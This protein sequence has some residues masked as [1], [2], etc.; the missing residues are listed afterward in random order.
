MKTLILS[1]K[2]SLFWILFIVAFNSF[3]QTV[4]YTDNFESGF[5]NWVD[6]G[7]NCRLTNPTSL[8]SGQTVELRNGTGT[9]VTYTNNINFT[10]YTSVSIEFIFRV[11]G[12][13]NGEDFDLQYSNNGGSS[14]TNLFTYTVG[15]NILTNT[16]YSHSI[17]LT[18]AAY[19]FSN[20]S[21]FRF[22]SNGNHNQDKVFIDNVVI[23]VFAGPEIDVRGSNISIAN[24]DT[25]PSIGDNTDYGNVN[26]GSIV[27]KVFTIHNTGSGSLNIS[28]ITLSN[29]TDFAITGTPYS[30]PVAGGNSTSFNLRFKTLTVGTKTTTVTITNNDTDEGTYSFLVRAGAEQNFF[31][32]DGDGVYDNVDIDDDNDG[33]VDSEEELACKSSPTA[34]SVNYKFLNETFGTG[35]GRTTINTNNYAATTSYCYEDGTT[36]TNTAACPFMSSRILDDGEYTV[37]SKIT[38]TV[39]SDPENIHGDLAWTNAPDHTPGDT[40]GRMAVFNASF[41]PGVFY[42]TNITGVLSNIPITY[43]FWAMN[44]MSQAYYPGTIH[45]N[46]TVQFLDFS[47]NI[48]ATI[49][50]G[51]FGRCSGGTS[52]NSCSQNVWKQ[53]TTSVNLGD[54]TDFKV[55]FINN[56]S[57]GGGNDLAIDDIVIAQTLCDT[58]G[59]GVADVFDLDSDNDGIPDVVEAGLGNYSEGKA[60]LTNTIGWVDTNGNGMLDLAEGHITLDSDGDGR[61]NYLDLDSDNDAIFDVDE[62]G[63]GNTADV[64]FQNGD[65]DIDGDGVGDGPDSDSVRL[66]DFDSDGTT[67][68]FT[69]GI[70]DIYD[71]YNGSSFAAAYGNSNQ[72]S[73]YTYFVK[74][75]DNDGIPDYIDIT[76]DGSTYDISHTLYASLDTNNDGRV[77]G[78]GD[79]DKDGILDLFDTND[80]LFGSPRDLDR[81]LHLYF[82]GRNDYAQDV[83][84]IN[85]WGEVSMMGWIKI[86]PTGTGVQRVMGQNQFYL[87]LQSNRTMRVVANGNLLTS[88]RL[89]TNRWTHVAATYSSSS[90]LLKLYINGAEVGSTSVSGSLPSDSAL[91]TLGKNATA[92]NRYFQGFMEEVRIFNKALSADEIQ[93]MV[94]QEIQN[95]GG[96][97]RGAI[98]PRDITNYISATNIVPLNWSSLKRYYRMD[99]YKGDII[100]DLSTAAIDVS[101]G[102]RIYNT[103]IIDYQ[104]AP[105]PFVTNQSGTLSTAVNVTA[106][107]VF[108]NDAITYDWSIVHVKDKGINYSGTQKHLGLIINQLDASSTPIDFNVQGDSELNVSWYLKVDGTINLEGE[109]QLVQ[110]DDSVLDVSSRGKLQKNQQGT[111]DKFTYNYWSSPVGVSNTTTNNNSYRVRDVMKDGPNN[112]NW[113]TSGYNGT[114]TSPVGIADY[115][116]WK[117]ANLPDDSYASWQHVRSTGTMRAGEGF[118]MKG[119]GTGSILT[120][121]QYL[122][123]GKPNNGNID[124]T[125]NA[126]NDY[127]VGNPYPSAIDA[128]K[129]IIDNGPVIAG[130][131]STTGTLYFWEHWGGGSHNL[132]DYQGGYAT[133][134][135]SGGTPSASLGTN[136]PDVGT[137][138]VPTKVPGRYIPV[139]QGFF[140]VAEGAGGT[141]KFRNSQRI[142]MPEGTANSVFVRSAENATTT[143]YNP[144]GEDLRMKFRIGFNSVNTIHR[145]LLLTVDDNATIDIDWGYD[146]AHIDEQMDDMYW[147]INSE[148]FNIQGVDTIT[149]ASIVPLGLHL[150]DGGQTKISIDHLENVPDDV[151]IFVHDKIT[152]IYHN[153]RQQGD[154]VFNLAPGTYL[155]RYEI[156][157]REGSA[158]GVDENDLTALEVY[159]ANAMESIVLV[160][161][162]LREIKSV[163]MFNLLGQSVVTIKPIENVTYSEY[164]VKNLSV[165]TYIV[166]MITDH[167]TTSKKVLVK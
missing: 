67:E 32:S 48:L 131:G 112:I 89:T 92:N 95:N 35:T 4:L 99:T 136:D 61:P 66:K 135:L 2:Q 116:I 18:D 117:F 140:V 129:F 161:P 124:L 56:A 128:D 121:Q 150:R 137:G 29:N 81:K 157:F 106:D 162:T 151:N 152:N 42:E 53:F 14:Y 100:D 30:S 17:T 111:A 142:F 166:K 38:G 86:D 9:S 97:V 91:L 34:T 122:F 149:E 24:N 13:S 79:A 94:Y 158:L 46:I 101:S 27:T 78:S 26:V 104:N 164:K 72:G 145:Q 20:N 36:G 119:P 12:M 62:S 11:E 114:N 10:P 58:D 1:L 160:N 115:W 123:T 49:N 22:R 57:G 6:G 108:G 70:L 40:N 47:G 73:G 52:D 7:G 31:D 141:I 155:D 75:S 132:G 65:G 39:A 19:S 110:G 167:G 55:R 125:L 41:T 113:L 64:K 5:G 93:K 90:G 134:N 43:S 45:P 68:T 87:E 156:T 102:A 77:D 59:D 138:G 60:T 25:T 144:D 88:A 76:S 71:Y 126:G 80:A 159:Y 23:T 3:S 63:A 54:I 133:Y 98:I 148:K 118:T 82:D 37:V 153:L 21:R 51:P 105:L 143:N 83:S 16:N 109:S 147:M 130:N 15:S 85:G 154:Y 120:P 96:T 44:I 139:S 103:K 28:G 127:L 163:E 107:G 8:N 50:T 146:A 74:D 33:I 69:D 165:G 84:V